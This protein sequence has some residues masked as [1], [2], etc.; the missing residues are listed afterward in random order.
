MS[1][2]IIKLKEHNQLSFR[3][4]RQLVRIL[5]H[6]SIKRAM[7]LTRRKK[8]AKSLIIAVN[9]LQVPGRGKKPLF[10]SIVVGMN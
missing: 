3:V 5:P 6:L 2:S 4:G 7:K 8:Y 10:S 9:I 1:K